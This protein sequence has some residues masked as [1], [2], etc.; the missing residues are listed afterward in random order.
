MAQTTK[1]IG[2]RLRRPVGLM[3]AL[4]VVA[5]GLSACDSSRQSV[6]GLAPCGG[7]AMQGWIGQPVGPIGGQIPGVRILDSG[8][9]GTYDFRPERLNV[10]VD[11]DG[12]VT[13]LSCG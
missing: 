9:S 1:Q 8:S 4:S 5:L 3:V 2:Q 6:S 10:H 11:S 12:V 13:G 7:D